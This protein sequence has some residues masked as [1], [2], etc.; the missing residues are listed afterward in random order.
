M[1]VQES[2]IDV[3]QIYSHA[4]LQGKPRSTLTELF[5]R[6]MPHLRCK[7]QLQTPTSRVFMT[8]DVIESKESAQHDIRY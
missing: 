6:P 5:F 2:L 4:I 8:P 3:S 1:D 7:D